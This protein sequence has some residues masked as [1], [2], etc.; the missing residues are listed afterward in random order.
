[1]LVC[2]HGDVT[3]F[4]EARGMVIVE[5]YEGDLEKYEGVCRILVTGAEM[6]EYEYYYLKGKLFAGGIELVSTRYTDDELLSGY[7]AYAGKRGAEERRKKYGGRQRFGFSD[8]VLTATGRA[9]VTR[10]FELRDRGYSYRMI[11]E[12]DGVHHPD[13]RKLS[14]STIQIII[15]NRSE[16][17]REEK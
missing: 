15:K 6:T 4:C 13:G 16:Y 14:I 17:E 1:M 7:A 9:V 11:R 12:D 3:G 8:G 2:A 5:Q 10:I